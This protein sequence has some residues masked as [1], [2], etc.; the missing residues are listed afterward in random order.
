MSAQL[1]LQEP[2]QL[3]PTEVHEITSYSARRCIPS[4]ADLMGFT[5]AER[6]KMGGWNS[7]ECRLAKRQATMPDHYSHHRLHTALQAKAAITLLACKLAAEVDEEDDNLDWHQLGTTAT[8]AFWMAEARRLVL[9]APPKHDAKHDKAS[10]EA[11]SS[12]D[13]SSSCSSA[14]VS[15]DASGCE[16]MNMLWALSS[17]SKGH[18]HIFAGGSST[19]TRTHCGRTLAR[20][21][22]GSGDA[23]A[24][25][26]KAPWSPRCAAERRRLLGI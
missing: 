12:E 4:L 18:L 3:S 2:L 20:P 16:P 23:H 24:S 13:E 15:S 22:L 14:A 1:F 26:T 25:E 17:G 21:E 11:P 6:L 8:P 10:R 5:P 7:E 19:K 9:P